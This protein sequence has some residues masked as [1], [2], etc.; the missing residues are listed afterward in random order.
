M[1]KKA[2]ACRFLST[3]SPGAGASSGTICDSGLASVSLQQARHLRGEDA[4]IAA[5]LGID[6]AGM[7]DRP[8]ERAGK[9]SSG[10]VCSIAGADVAAAEMR[11]IGEADHEVDDQ[12]RR[13]RAEPDWIV[14]KPCLR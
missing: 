7:R 9:A 3:S 4:G 14:P 10:T 8:A 5:V 13:R 1:P 11:G 2:E 12:Q 6:H